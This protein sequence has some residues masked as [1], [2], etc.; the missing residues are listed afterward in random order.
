[1]A[2]MTGMNVKVLITNATNTDDVLAGQR[3]ATL[4]RQADTIDSTSKDTAGFWKESLAGF[5][6]WGVD[7]DGAYVE[8]DAAYATLE[9]AYLNNTDVGIVVEFP[10]GAKYTGRATIKDFSLELPY[11]GLVTYKLQFD[12]NGALTKA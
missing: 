4:K 2:K 5:K 9:A 12:G 6:S 8:S 1:M 7:C 3:N 10:S 11:D